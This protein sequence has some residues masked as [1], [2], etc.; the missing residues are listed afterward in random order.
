[1]KVFSPQTR[2]KVN[3]KKVGLILRQKNYKNYQVRRKIV[4][5]TN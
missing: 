1:M 2:L 4:K 3:N 5:M